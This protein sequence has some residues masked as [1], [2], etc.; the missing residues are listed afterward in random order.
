MLFL[1]SFLFVTYCCCCFLLLFFFCSLSVLLA[2]VFVSSNTAC[3][4]SA[5]GSA[6]CIKFGDSKV[7]F[8]GPTHSFTSCQIAVKGWALGTY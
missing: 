1:F 6:A 2:I 7:R 4:V 3:P 5:V 8:P